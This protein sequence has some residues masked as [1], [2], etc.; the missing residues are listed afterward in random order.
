M[1]FIILATKEFLSCVEADK[2]AKDSYDKLVEAE[3][4]DFASSHVTVWEPFE[5]YS[6][7][8]VL[9]LIQSLSEIFETVDQNGYEKGYAEGE[10]DAENY[11]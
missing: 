4:T 7:L 3:S 9:N 1:S 8:E 2:E 10:K 6:V 5:N 11:N